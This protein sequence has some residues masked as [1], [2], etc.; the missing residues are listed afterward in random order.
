MHVPKDIEGHILK[1]MHSV[2]QI[3]LEIDK[4]VS[5]HFANLLYLKDVVESKYRT[6]LSHLNMMRSELSN[7]IK[8]R[9]E[10]KKEGGK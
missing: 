9:E 2:N 3:L 1:K 4:L 6:I 7:A 10:E 5:I 8:A